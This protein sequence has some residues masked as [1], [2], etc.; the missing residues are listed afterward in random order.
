MFPTLRYNYTVSKR[1]LLIVSIFTAG[2]GLLSLVGG[3]LY[4]IQVRELAENSRVIPMLSTP[5]SPL[6]SQASIK[7]LNLENAIP[8]FEDND[9]ICSE[10]LEIF[11]QAYYRIS[12]EQKTPDYDMIIHVFT[13]SDQKNITLIDAQIDQLGTPSDDQA[14]NFLGFI[15][16]LPIE[17]MDPGALKQWIKMT[18]PSLDKSPGMVADRTLNGLELR[19]YGPPK[20]RSLEMVTEK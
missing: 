11:Q 19:L 15:S 7:G 2:I 20:N 18:L 5:I 13:T 6:S 3:L 16:Q 4:N 1:L 12:C 17:K 8:V 9:F 10:K 14:V